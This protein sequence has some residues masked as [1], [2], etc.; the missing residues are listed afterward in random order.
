[1]FDSLKEKVLNLVDGPLSK[2]LII[3]IIFK[4]AMKEELKFTFIS[5]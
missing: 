4:I 5:C 1:M 3:L 2:Y